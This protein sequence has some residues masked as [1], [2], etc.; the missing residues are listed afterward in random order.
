METRSGGRKRGRTPFG[1]PTVVGWDWDAL[2]TQGLRAGLTV[3]GFW[4]LTPRETQRVFEAAAWRWRTEQRRLMHAAW[5]VAALGRAKKMPS[6]RRVL[7]EDRARRLT[8][9]EAAT[10]RAEF[11]E[12]KERMGGDRKGIGVRG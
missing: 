5:H 8:P 2:L 4:G 11:E 3:E 9:G 6:L 1:G 12:L 7:G 10:R